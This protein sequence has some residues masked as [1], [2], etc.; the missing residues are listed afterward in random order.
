MTPASD[1]R[2]FGVLADVASL[3][4]VE[5]PSASLAKPQ[6]RWSPA[7]HAQWREQKNIEPNR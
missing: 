7:N 4:N 5:T 3:G 6:F 1:F 2:A